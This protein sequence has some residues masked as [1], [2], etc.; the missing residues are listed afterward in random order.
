MKN[1]TP[2]QNQLKEF[3]IAYQY[4]NQKIP[5][6]QT[7][8]GSLGVSVARIQ[9]IISALTRKH[10]IVRENIYKISA[11][12]SAGALPEKNEV[13]GNTGEELGRPLL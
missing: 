2:R 8:A 6:L 5:T 1:L 12:T 7:M 4:Q 13:I 3:I 9:H 11:T 10:A